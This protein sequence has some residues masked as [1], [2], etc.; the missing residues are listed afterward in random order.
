[1]PYTIKNSAGTIVATIPDGAVDSTTTSIN[2][3]GKNVTGYG[4]FQNE[5]FLYL[6]ENFS[7][8]TPPSNPVQGQIWFDN[9]YDVTNPN[10]TSNQLKLK[11]WDGSEWK[12]VSNL[13]TGPQS[14]TPSN[15]TVGDFYYD[16]TNNILKIWNGS[17]FD[18]VG[19]NVPGFGKSRLEGAIIAGK[20]PN[21]NTTVNFPVLY[22]YIDNTIVG[23]YSNVTFIPNTS[24]SQLYVGQDGL[25]DIKKGWNSFNG[26]LLNGIADSATSLFDGTNYISLTNLIRADVS[27]SQTIISPLS[28]SSTLSVSGN[29]T[30]TAG[31]AGNLTGNVIG[32][33]TGNVTGNLTGNVTG[34]LTGNVTALTVA[35]TSYTTSPTVRTSTLRTYDGSTMV[36]DA[37][38]NV[39]ADTRP[40]FYGVLQGD[41]NAATVQTGIVI[42]SGS[43][44]AAGG[45]IGGLTGNVTGSVIGNVT[46]NAGTVTDGMY[47]STTQ[48]VTGQKTFSGPV[49]HNGNLAAAY[50]TVS[51]MT[52]QVATLNSAT[53]SNSNIQ[54]ATLSDSLY[55][56][57][58]SI[59]NSGT[60]LDIQSNNTTLPTQH[61]VK[62]YVDA[63]VARAIAAIPPPPRANLQDIVQSI[64]G[65]IDLY[66]S[67]AGIGSGDGGGF[68]GGSGWSGWSN[69]VNG[70]T[71][72]GGG[73]RVDA[74]R[75]S[76]L[77][78][79]DGS[80]GPQI[81]LTIDLGTVLGLSNDPNN[82]YWRGNYDFNIAP[83]LTRIA[84]RRQT[85]YGMGQGNWYV[86]CSP[87]ST[88]NTDGN[89]GSFL[90]TVGVTDYGHPYHGTN[91]Q[92]GWLGIASRGRN[93]NGL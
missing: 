38:Y 52:A 39:N 67:A 30:A 15:P 19:T 33:V 76:S 21:T 58:S 6:L 87:V 5:N 91:I 25:G 82:L 86:Y 10:A 84:D 28:L 56:T 71:I 64:V 77:F 66:M 51:N 47:L 20:Y 31:V 53:I 42:S 92:A 79:G 85:Y 22:M 45:F 68:T 12:F 63:G 54:F 3:V 14:F 35:A 7:K 4:A 1:M 29:I 46:G 17:I 34:N 49:I 24:I 61:A 9:T 73:G 44:T 60:W 37:N 18:Y 57:V 23:L 90:L 43:I 89:W 55:T 40:R 74:K 93:Y 27:S 26:S 36:I 2:I 13:T 72:T 88:N 16:T 41:V 69:Q 65:T 70:S 62:V 75:S 59:T 48:T 50:F 81:Q 8:I 32:N 80:G 83:S 11:V 78:Y